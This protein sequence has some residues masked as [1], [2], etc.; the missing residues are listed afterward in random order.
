IVA[1]AHELGK[2]VVAEGVEAS[3]D[4]DF[5]R[6]IGCEYAQGFYFGEPMSEKGA[7]SLVSALAKAEKKKAKK[8]RPRILPAPGRKQPVSGAAKK[9]APSA[10]ASKEKTGGQPKTAAAGAPMPVNGVTT[11]QA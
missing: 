6:S 7:M 8:A 5:L 11:R 3:E 1:M 9:P 10:P 4:A 2:K